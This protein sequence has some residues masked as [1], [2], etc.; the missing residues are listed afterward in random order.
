MP[1]VLISDKL[2]PAAVAIFQRRGIDVDLKPG[3]SAAD[4]RAIIAPY[5][6]L[7]VRS[8]TKVTRELLEAAPNL[9]VV[10]RAGIGVDNVDVKS[11]TARGVVVMN[12]PHGNTITTAE[13]AIAMMFALARQIPEASTSTR[14][15][16]WEKNRFLGVELTGKMLGV[17]GCGN[18]GAIVADRAVGL[19]MKVIA[20]DPF[21]AEKRA[22]TLGVEKVELDDLLSRADIITLH[23]PLTDA[24]RNILSREAL[25][26]TRKGVRIIN[27]ARGGLLDEAALADAIR[28]GHVAGAALDVFETEPA[29]ASPLFTLENVV[30]T[31]HLG[32]AT[33]EA[34]ENVALQ[35]AEQMSDFLLTGA[36]AN[37]IN[38]P[39]VSAE[40]APRL[41]PYMELCRLLGGF[42]GQLTQ[43]REGM[44][45]RVVIEYE[46]LA[47][48]LNQRPLTA[49]VL[50]GLMAPMMEGVNMV[51]APVAAREH[52]IEVAETVHDRPSE[53]QTLVRVTIEADKLTR[54]VAGTLFAGARPR[55]VEIKGIPVEADFAPH[56]LYVTN[57]DKPGFIGRFGATLAGA[58]INI[59][60]FHL[61][62]SAPGGDAICLVAVD[63]QVPEDVLAMVR[64]LP[65]VVQATALAF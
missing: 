16:K 53:Y 45:R 27:C 50:A 64:T 3:L 55:L 52:G 20:Y 58:G 51:N 8:A 23:T 41:K 25:V 18:I 60:T 59:A 19:K 48:A 15:G 44:I 34:Q 39:S 24:T 6:G 36:V 13:H 40:D 63:E 57:Q 61:G 2:S 43:A 46:G 12:T 1:K 38:M 49:A 14:A 47:A 10:G 26:K 9:K 65:L 62:R 29:V 7:A 37:A 28:S 21:L 17:I 35:V 42:A 30:C 22:V 31:P 54:S 56:M 4:L 33:M 32:A 11:A 5:D